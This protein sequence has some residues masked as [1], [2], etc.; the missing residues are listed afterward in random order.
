MLNCKAIIWDYNGT[1]LND[2]SIGVECIN[3]MLSKRELP[4]LSVERYREV[5]T[6][7][8]KK[9]YESVGFDFN[10]EDWDKAAKEFIQHYTSLLPQSEI[11][12]EA[13]ELLSKFSANG[14]KQFILSAMEQNMLNQ[15]TQNENIITYFDEISGIDNIYASSKIKN[16]LQL[17]KKYKLQ[18]K[19]VCLLGDTT[20]DYEV[21]KELGCQCILIA[22]G[23][24]S[25]NKL[26]QTGCPIVVNDLNDIIKN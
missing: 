11:F 15:S 1:L 20:H 21:A 7:P 5:F 3:R 10:R 19:E 8:V 14:K 6:F 22:A 17:L 23:H 25:F 26:K 16:G 4:L 9:Y 13:L 24:Q 18:A 2:L 12:P